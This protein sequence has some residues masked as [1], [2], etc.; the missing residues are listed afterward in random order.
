MIPHRKAPVL[1]LLLLSLLALA[2]GAQAQDPVTP[3]DRGLS[4]EIETADAAPSTAAFTAAM[5]RM[6]GDMAIPFTG[7]ADVDFIRAMIAQ[8]RGTIAMAGI[9]LDNG[10]DPA[11]RK[12][13][14]AVIARVSAEDRQMQD[15][16][17]QHPPR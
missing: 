2:P 11:A 13:A 16:L 9:E 14:H 1:S 7:D 17:A 8:H 15:W 4:A 6:Q 12:L 3:F 10:N 5:A